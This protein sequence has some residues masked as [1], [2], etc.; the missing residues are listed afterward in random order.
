[1]SIY[2]TAVARAAQNS[3]ISLNKGSADGLEI[4]HV[5]AIIK[6]GRTVTDNTVTPRQTIKLPDESNGLAMV[7]R[8]FD[9]VSYA[10]ILQVNDGVKVGDRLINP[11]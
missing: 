6:D 7:F 8:T 11:R 3:V 9:K 1:M 4:G 5:L 10:L 2:G